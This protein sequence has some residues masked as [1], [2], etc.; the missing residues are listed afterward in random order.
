MPVQKARHYE[1]IFLVNQGIDQATRG[2]ERLQEISGFSKEFYKDSLAMLEHDRA[3]VNLQ[4]FADNEPTE[5]KDATI[6]ER[7]TNK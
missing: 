1:A 7:R 3:L 6:H 5:K 4:Y 2:L